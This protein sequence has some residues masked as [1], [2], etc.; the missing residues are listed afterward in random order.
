MSM[1][2]IPATMRQRVLYEAREIWK[3]DFVTFD[4]E[5]TGKSPGDQIIQWAVC[6]KDASVLGSGFVK[7][8]IPITR[9]AFEIHGIT[10]EKLSNAPSFAEAWPTLRPLLTGK[11]VVIYN[12]GFDLG[13]LW[14]SA[15]A[16]GIDIPYNLIETLCAM[17]LFARF[18]GQVH[19]H[20]GSYTWQKLNEVAIPCLEIEVPGDPHHAEHD[21]AATALLIKR[22]AEM[23]DE[24]LPPGWHP[25]VDVKC[26]GCQRETKECAESDEIWYCFS[27][28]LDRGLFHR[29]PGCKSMIKSPVTGDPSNDLC[30][31][32]QNELHKEKMLLTGEWH[33]CPNTRPFDV[34]IVKTADQNELC[35]PCQRQRMWRL[36]QEEAERARQERIQQERK[37]N[38]RQYNS[39]YRKRKKER[40]VENRRRAEQG[41]PPLDVQK[42]VVPE[43]FDHH[44]HH[45][46]RIKHEDGSIELHCLKCDASWSREPRSWCADLKTYR[47]WMSIPA[48]LKTRTQLLKI[49]LK[50]APE[51]KAVAVVEG[52]FDRYYLY[53]VADCVAVQPRKPQTTP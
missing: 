34:H 16:V 32:C 6:S 5:T 12:A 29:C 4:T 35:E 18:Y 51:Q 28:S 44:G 13:R 10:Q 22:L 47:N 41:L 15:S 52:S 27:C 17:E 39:D 37:E 8:T 20:W 45:F 42:P 48:H 23:A 3:S 38:R 19:E 36:Q 14:D 9:G 50:P 21:A 53:K 49:K 31:Y 40:E 24:E 1:S 26:A 7:P 30:H 43:F 33:R 25:P 11:T 46:Q 2:E